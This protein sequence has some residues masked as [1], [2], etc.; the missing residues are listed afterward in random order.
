MSKNP[1]NNRQECPSYGWKS[2]KAACELSY[3]MRLGH[4]KMRLADCN[5][6]KYHDSKGNSKFSGQL[7][8]INMSQKLTKSQN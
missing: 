5:A 4:L 7:G 6:V 8:R 2:D 3:L 1:R